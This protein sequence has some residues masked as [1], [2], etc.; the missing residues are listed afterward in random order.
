MQTSKLFR[1]L[2]AAL[3]LV[4]ALAAVAAADAVGHLTMATGQVDLL[5]GGKLPAVALKVNDKVSPGDIIRTK[6][7]SRAQITF[8]DNSVLTI[9]PDSRIAIA[10]YHPLQETMHHLTSALQFSRQFMLDFLQALPSL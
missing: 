9:S 4:M 5:K 3:A 2:V 1:L 10:E 7:M 8:I 6:S